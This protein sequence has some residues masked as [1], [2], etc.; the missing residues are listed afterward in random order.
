MTIADKIAADFKEALKSVDKIKIS[1]LRMI[2]SAMKNREIEKGGPLND[3]DIHAILR[4]YEKR[5]KESIEQFSKGGRTDLVEK[6]H[7]EL[8][9]VQRYLPQQLGEEE[10]R[11]TIQDVLYE[12]GA[13]GPRDMGKAMKAVMAKVKGRA[14]GK[15]VHTIVK[16]MLEA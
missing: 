4:S 2:K 8:L 16:E 7:G 14:D 9:V 1:V 11:R 13:A 5:S 10:L 15:L 12:V 6:E 3:D